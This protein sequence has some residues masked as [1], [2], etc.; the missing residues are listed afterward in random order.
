M[1][2]Q[3]TFR[4]GTQVTVKTI[5]LKDTWYKFP[6]ELQWGE[7]HLELFALQTIET[8]SKQLTKKGHYRTLNVTLDK[9]LKEIYFN[10]EMNRR[11]CGSY[12]E[13]VTNLPPTLQTAASTTSFDQN[14]L[15]IL[16]KL[17]THQRR[18]VNLSQV[19]KNFIIKKYSGKENA[20]KWLECFEKE[21]ERHH[22]I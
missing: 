14:L 13:E 6:D 11:F 7:L 16:E 5:K 2:A 17:S 18:E 3:V 8:A 20:V 22:T 15:K 10:E 9:K 4:D 12:L 1:M 21:C 19:Q